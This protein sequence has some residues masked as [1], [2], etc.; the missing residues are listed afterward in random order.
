MKAIGLFY[1]WVVCCVLSFSAANA[2]Q[3]KEWSFLLF[4]N[5]NN[6]LASFGEMNLNQLETVGSSKDVNFVVQWGDMNSTETKRMLMV[7]DS[8]E[9]KITSP[10]VET[11]PRVDMGS[12]EELVKFVAWAKEKYPAKHY[13]IATWDHGSG[14]DRKSRCQPHRG[15][16]FD[17][18]SGNYITTEQLGLAMAQAAKI[19]GHKVD[20]LGHDACLMSMVEIAAE[21]ADS[22]DV[23]VASEE[24]EPGAGWP[25]H[26]MAEGWVKNP[27]ASALEVG[28][29]F[30]EAYIKSPLL[31]GRELTLSALN[32]NETAGL[33]TALAALSKEITKLSAEK[34]SVVRDAASS[35]LGFSADGVDIGHWVDKLMASQS[36]HEIASGSLK[37]VKTALGKYVATNGT[38][39]DMKD[40]Q[41]VAV[42]IPVDGVKSKSTEETYSKLKFNKATNW[43]SAIKAVS[44]K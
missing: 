8:D 36:Q 37:A 32:L 19:I 3:E 34:V 30:V 31:E 1:A 10:V 25:Y 20:I 28:K 40:A 2:V 35:A 13:F 43:L 15:I 23:H 14:W 24:L 5:G 22:V 38:S 18:H 29:I 12:Y 33:T 39:E 9:D 26:L 17:D 41:G 4:L 27:K 44:S 11:L 42:W 16:S 6:N 7:K 21:V